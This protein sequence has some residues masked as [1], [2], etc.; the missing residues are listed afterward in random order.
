MNR[1]QALLES[2]HIFT[3]DTEK[4]IYTIPNCGYCNHAQNNGS[5]RHPCPN[6]RNCD[7]VRSQGKEKSNIPMDEKKLNEMQKLVIETKLAF[8]EILTSM[9][10][11]M[12]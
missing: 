1:T 4:Q 7:Y 3:E 5:Q 8:D 12:L 9:N 2:L 11:R 10:E 6:P